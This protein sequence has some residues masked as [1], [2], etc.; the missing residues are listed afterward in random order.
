MI[1]R[2]AQKNAAIDS[3][4]DIVYYVVT[5][6]DERFIAAKHGEYW[7]TWQVHGQ[8]DSSFWGHYGF[9]TK[10]DAIHDAMVR[11]GLAEPYC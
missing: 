3:A 10:E 9:V 8:D 5:E 6:F 4:D 2:I 1:D 11:A 7:A